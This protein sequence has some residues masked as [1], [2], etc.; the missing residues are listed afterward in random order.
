MPGVNNK[1]SKPQC[2]YV[3]TSSTP[4]PVVMLMAG[5]PT[6]RKIIPLALVALLALSVV[7]FPAASIDRSEQIEVEDTNSYDYVI[8]ADGDNSGNFHLLYESEASGADYGDIAYRKVDPTGDTLVG[9]VKLTP[10]NQDTSPT[11]KA[12][13]ADSAGRV[14][15]VFITRTESQDDYA[16]FYAQVGSDGSV[17]VSPKVVHYEDTSHPLGLDIEV[18]SS[19]NA[20][21]VWHQTTDPP[22]IMWAKVSSSGAI[23][24]DPD[25]IAVDLGFGGTVEYPRLGVTSNGESLVV[26]QQTDNGLPTTRTSIWFVHLNSHGNEA[27]GPQEIISH[28]VYNLQYLEA[29]GNALDDELHVVYEQNNDIGYARVEADG[30]V[31]TTRTIYGDLVGEGTTPDVGVAKNG[32]MLISYGR[33]DN[34]ASDWNNWATAY[35]YDDDDWDAHLEVSDTPSSFGRPA[36]V[37]GMGAVF[38]HEG[39]DLQMVTL[40]QDA[41]NH[42]PVPSLDVSPDPVGVGQT[43]TFDGSGSSDPDDGD[44]VESYN[45]DFGDGQRSGWISSSS[46]THSYTSPGTYRAELVVR[47]TQGLESTTIATD[48]VQVTSDPVNQAPTAVVSATPTTADTGQTVTFTGTSSTDPDGTVQ[49]YRFDYGDGQESGWVSNGVQTHAYTSEGTYTAT[50]WVKDDEGA[51]SLPDTVRVTVEHTNQAPTATIVSVLPNPAMQGEDVTFTG[52]GEDSDGEVTAYVWE[53]EFDGIISTNATFTTKTLSPGTHTITFKVKD[54]ENVWSE[55]VTKMVEVRTNTPFTMEDLTQM[56]TQVYT[57]KLVEF[58]VMY[59]DVDND[60]PTVFNL[61]IFTGGDWKT[62]QLNEF[63]SADKNYVDGKVY[64]FNKK[65][66]DE[67]DYQYSFEFANNK[68]SK[69]STTAVEFNVKQTPGLFPAWEAGPASGAIILAAL[70]MTIAL[71]RRRMSAS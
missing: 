55:E 37:S 33:R 3:I 7:P 14:H 1:P 44:D 45:F 13:A 19:G 59:T 8:R 32:D 41:E 69:R 52:T 51:E 27:D 15:T 56:D 70:A 62:E 28:A 48:N 21:I 60:R 29:A 67:G 10:A 65:F 43:V 31:A 6:F 23:L 64:Y 46:T 47:D 9:P 50:L 39:G 58:R 63:T 17:S 66:T 36:A 16:L 18:D 57:D 68:N 20:Y 26:W 54:D 71:R 38:W 34:A 2:I 5:S 42:P 49:L 4:Y 35:W 53:S 11:N 22:S 30:T 24:E 25:A 12:I 61:L 40:T